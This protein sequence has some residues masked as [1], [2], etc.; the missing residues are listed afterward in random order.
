[1]STE[2]KAVRKEWAAGAQSYWVTNINTHSR[3]IPFS[4]YLHTSSISHC[5]R[6]SRVG[7]EDVNSQ[8]FQPFHGAVKQLWGQR[9][10]S[11]KE[12]QVLTVR[13][14]TGMHSSGKDKGIWPGIN[15]IYI[16]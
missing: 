16:S 8:C 5:L 15:S 9:K 2:G 4:G 3:V 14:P 11:G 6:A 10:D 7:W 12:M 13:S 1:M